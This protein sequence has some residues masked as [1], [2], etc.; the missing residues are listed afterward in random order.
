MEQH[1]AG[2]HDKNH[3]KRQLGR[4]R[5]ADIECKAQRDDK[6]GNR[7]RDRRLLEKAPY[8]FAEHSRQHQQRRREEDRVFEVLLNT[9]GAIRPAKMPPSTPP[10]DVHR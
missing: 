7:E 8:A 3:L 4:E 10:N 2:Q 6:R 1:E 5:K 9:F